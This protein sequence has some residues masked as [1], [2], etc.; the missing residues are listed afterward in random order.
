M[1][2][3]FDI[4]YINFGQQFELFADFLV[5]ELCGSTEAMSVLSDIGVDPC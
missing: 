5:C 1:T 3:M 2:W 4:L